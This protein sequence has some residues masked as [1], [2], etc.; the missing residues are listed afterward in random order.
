MA[1][2]WTPVETSYSDTLSWKWLDKP[3]ISMQDKA[4]ILKV[5]N[6]FFF[7]GRFGP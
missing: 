2:I 4:L 1:K 3:A 6:C 7:F 5:S